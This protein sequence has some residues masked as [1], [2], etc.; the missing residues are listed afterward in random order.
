[1]ALFGLKGQ[2][3]VKLDEGNF[4]TIAASDALANKKIVAYYFSENW[5]GSKWYFTPRLKDAYEVLSSYSSDIE[6][7]FVSSD[8][9]QDEMKRY[10]KESHGPWLAASHKSDL[11]QSLQTK[12]A[13]LQYF[14][15]FE[16]ILVVCKSNGSVI[17]KEGIFDF[18]GPEGMKRWL[19][20]A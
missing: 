15:H 17:T 14:I 6:V 3:L 18:E 7:V 5:N 9:T 16:P 2:T 4:K 19:E 20:K 10:M 13:L 8:C 12:F 11:A 1:M